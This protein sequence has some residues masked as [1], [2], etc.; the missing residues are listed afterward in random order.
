M[1]IKKYQAGGIYYT[2]YFRETTSQV[3][4]QNAQP[5]KETTSKEDNLIQKEIIQVLKENGLPNDV[6]YFLSSANTF[7]KKSQNVGYSLGESK[8]DSYDMSNLIRVISLA[9]RVKHNKELHEDASKQIISQGSGSDVAI[10]DTGNLYVINDKKDITTISPNE[11]YKNSNDYQILTNS[12]L[13]HLREN[14]PQ[15]T[16]KSGI[17]SDLANTVGM[18]SIVDYVKSTISAFGTNEASNKFEKY[19]I[20]NKDK[21]EK[22]FEQL[23]GLE[24]PDGVYKASIEQSSSNQGYNDQ[25]SLELAVNY[26]YNTL[27]PN[28]KNVLRA[29]A[30]AEGLNPNNVKDVQRL[31]TLAVLEHTNHSIT[32]QQSLNYD[33]TTSKTYGFGDNSKSDKQRPESRLEMVAADTPS[34]SINIL[35]GGNQSRSGFIISAQPVGKF[36]NN[37]GKQLGMD[38]IGNILLNDE[39]GH[40][41]DNSS[42]SFGNKHL[43]ET[44]LNRVVY[45]G[46]STIH[47]T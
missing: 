31:L 46:T 7:L 44:D 14:L 12:E 41:V 2:P 26:L 37:S 13:L 42:I 23:L 47:R 17:L 5:E 20:K 36:Q 1:K 9:N 16:Y 38:T 34:K 40:I 30:A 25:E 11:Y 10:S 33:N 4:S 24:S 15:L 43:S 35:I 45:D 3:V 22:G 18:K 32:N 27:Q 19:T 6:D 21:I 39:I 28:M 8:N 29:N